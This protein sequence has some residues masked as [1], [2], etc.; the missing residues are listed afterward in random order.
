[1]SSLP[2]QPVQYDMAL[3]GVF[4]RPYYSTSTTHRPSIPLLQLGR[5]GRRVG[6]ILCGLFLLVI[7][8]K[9]QFQYIRSDLQGKNNKYESK[10]KWLFNET[11]LAGDCCI[12]FPLPLLKQNVRETFLA[13][14][15]TP[16]S[17]YSMMTIIQRKNKVKNSISKPRKKLRKLQILVRLY[18]TFGPRFSTTFFFV[19]ITKRCLKWNIGNRLYAVGSH[20]YR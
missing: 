4:V 9:V 12:K 18:K 3:A 15:S 10:L 1:M 13:W 5:A 6:S 7:S 2:G 16:S 14:A 11:T 8:V 19:K 20:S 17:L